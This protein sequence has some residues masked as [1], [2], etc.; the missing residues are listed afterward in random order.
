MGEMALEVSDLILSLVPYVPGKPIEETRREFGL[1][2]VV[3][4]AS[5]ENPWGPSPKALLA[6]KDQLTE[7]HRYPDP[8][9][10]DLKVRY[11]KS[12]GVDPIQ[13]VFGNGSDEIL[14]LLLKVFCSKGGR[15]L[16]F[17]KSFIAYKIAAQGTCIHVDE[18]PV[19]DKFEMDIELLKKSY[20][21]ETHRL[22]FLVNPNNPT[23][24]HL[25]IGAI[26]S[27]LEFIGPSTRTLV[28][29]D[30]AY[31]EFAR[32]KDYQSALGLLKKYPNVVI[33]RT[34][35][36]AYGLAGI[37]VG[38]MIA[39]PKV[40]DLINRVRKPFNV[41]TLGQIGALAALSDQAHVE[42]TRKLT[43]EG[44]EFF[45]KKLSHLHLEWIPSQANFILFKTSADCTFVFLELLKKGVILR[46]LK[47]YGMNQ[48]V[49]MSVG[50]KEENEFAMA[51]IA[52][53]VGAGVFT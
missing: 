9:C 8:S 39:D 28:V 2:K 44:L 11:S 16:M 20:L 27:F 1:E 17:E 51:A 31:L 21:P 13:T 6:M 40:C 50:T 34:F 14:D 7:L 19:G 5:N 45:E 37:R 4:L 32:A 26:E 46:P 43:W 42:M 47:N 48:Y 41:N 30:E 12:L 38:V 10:H 22:V 25:S 18:A 3:K 23:G 36:K 49:R 15:A 52:G 35:S 53:L 24:R 29:I 33:L